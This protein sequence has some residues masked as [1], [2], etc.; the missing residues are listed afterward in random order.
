MA[1]LW[2]DFWL[3]ETGMGQQVTQLHDRC[4]II[5]III[6]IIIVIIIMITQPEVPWG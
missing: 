5:I 6:I 1:D 4:I 2:K 3:R